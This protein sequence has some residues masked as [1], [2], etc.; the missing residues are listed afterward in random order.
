HE[1]VPFE[2]ELVP[3]L[4]ASADLFLSCHRQSDPSCSYLEAMGC[5]LAVLGYDNAMW[6][7]LAAESG[8]GRVVRMGDVASLAASIAAWAADRPSLIAAGERALAYA[9][10][11]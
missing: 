10:A 7:R 9:R 2:E 11:H 3:A 5:G 8:G 4:R 1:P 6:S